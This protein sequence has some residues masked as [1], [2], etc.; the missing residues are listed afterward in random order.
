MGM[1]RIDGSCFFAAVFFV[2]SGIFRTILFGRRHGSHSESNFSL[3][4]AM[5]GD[6]LRTQWT[7]IDGVLHSLRIVQ[8]IMHILAW[9][10]TATVLF[11]AAWLQSSR[12]TS[13]MGLHC[14]IAF[15]GSTVAI[16]ELL[17]HMLML[18]SMMALQWMASDFTMENWYEIDG[19]G[20]DQ[21]DLI[22]W[23]VLEVVSISAH[24]MLLWVDT[25][26]YFLLATVLI[27]L[28]ISTKGQASPLSTSWSCF[29]LFIAILCILDVASEVLRF[30]NWR[31]FSQVCF[32]ISTANRCI[33]FP[34]WLMWLGVQLAVAPTAMKQEIDIADMEDD[35][36]T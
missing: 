32:W 18:G 21:Q 8:S 3:M 9:V 28:F 12:G 20:S 10:I 19:L 4:K 16:V 34:N 33:L 27:L 11:R 23:K 17:V 31:L 29:G 14:S 13:S 30:T 36:S 5:D 26:E 7:D 22:G 2:L 15:L 25:I 35:V 24:G 1:R 6:Y